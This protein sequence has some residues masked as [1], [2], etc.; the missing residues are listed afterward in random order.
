MV[1]GPRARAARRKMI[2]RVRRMYLAV[3]RRFRLT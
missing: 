1:R 2:A 3:I